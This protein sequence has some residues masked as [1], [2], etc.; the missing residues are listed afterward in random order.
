MSPRR[1]WLLSLYL[2][3]RHLL[4]RLLHWRF[5]KRGGTQGRVNSGSH[6]L[7]SHF[8]L[9]LGA[10][11]AD[12]YLFVLVAGHV[13]S[14]LR[15]LVAHAAA[16]LSAV[17]PSPVDKRELGV[18]HRAVSGRLVGR[19][20]LGLVDTSDRAGEAIVHGVAEVHLRHGQS[21]FKLLAHGQFLRLTAS[22]RGH[23]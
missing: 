15:A 22:R 7:I 10:V 14:I 11:G 18:A 17:V 20:V 12:A 16:T 2:C 23:R 9:G 8:Q 5:D 13:L 1:Y 21:H 19:P 3:F 6:D 4:S